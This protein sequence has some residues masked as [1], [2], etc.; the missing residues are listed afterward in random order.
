MEPPERSPTWRLIGPFQLILRIFDGYLPAAVERQTN[1][2]L[3]KTGTMNLTVK[4][5]GVHDVKWDGEQHD[6][7]HCH[8]DGELDGQQDGEHMDNTTLPQ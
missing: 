3:N 6:E 7:Q 5:D 2:K 1:R 8:Q 4:W